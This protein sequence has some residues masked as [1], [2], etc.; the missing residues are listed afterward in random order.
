MGMNW[1]LIKARAQIKEW[2]KAFLIAG[3]VKAF[4]I[5]GAV[6]VVLTALVMGLVMTL[7]V[8]AEDDHPPEQVVW[9]EAYFAGMNGA[10]QGVGLEP[11]TASDRQEAVHACVHDMWWTDVPPLK[12]E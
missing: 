10:R 1:I 4:L 11:Y 8:L 5:V 12:G 7:S 3:A 2:V 6:L 9:C